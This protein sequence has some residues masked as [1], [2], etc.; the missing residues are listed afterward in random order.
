LKLAIQR[1]LAAL[2]ENAALRECLSCNGMELVNGLGTERVIARLGISDIEIRQADTN[3]SRA[4]FQWRNH[5]SIREVSRDKNEIEWNSHQSWFET[6]LADPDRFLLIGQRAQTPLG[7]VRFDRQG[8]AAEIS[9][10]AVPGLAERG[11][12]QS[13][14][15]SAEMWLAD[16]HPDIR[17]IRAQVLGNN[18]RS[19][20]MFAGAGYEIESTYYSKRVQQI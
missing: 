5:P 11:V 2:A 1:H 15:H 3:D 18:S 20:K 16:H 17:K 14:L 8:D 9:I 13:L 19:H 10:Y 7:V 4:L 6:V 12:G